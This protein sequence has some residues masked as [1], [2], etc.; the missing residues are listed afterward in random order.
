MMSCASSAPAL[1]TPQ[2]SVKPAARTFSAA[3]TVRTF[4][5]VPGAPM[6]F[7][8]APELPAE[9]ISTICWLPAVPGSASR[10]SLSYSCALAL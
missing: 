6:V 4:F 10:T 8:P 1:V 9:K 7:G 3:P 2:P 5:A